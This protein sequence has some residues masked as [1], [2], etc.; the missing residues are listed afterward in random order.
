MATAILFS[1][2]PEMPVCTVEVD[3]PAELSSYFLDHFKMVRG[4]DWTAYTLD[5]AVPTSDPNPRGA[6]FLN[7][8][9]TDWETT[10][11]GPMLVFCDLTMTSAPIRPGLA[12]YLDDPQEAASARG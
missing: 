5:E 2:D 9:R 1:N 7:E 6:A 12:R 4:S 10:L 8:R 3:D 11:R